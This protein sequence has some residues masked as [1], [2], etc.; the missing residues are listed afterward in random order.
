MNESVR[1]AGAGV[2]V[3]LISVMLLI[4]IVPLV[5]AV[6]VSSVTSFNKSLSDATYINDQKAKV[7]EQSYMDVINQMNEALTVAANDP[8]VLNYITNPGSR[9]EAIAA[10]IGFAI[11]SS[12]KIFQIYFCKK[13]FIYNLD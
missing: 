9:N 6:V 13:Y 7:V 11:F 12:S 2:R 10:I 4:C 3:K 5:I 8:Y 1:K